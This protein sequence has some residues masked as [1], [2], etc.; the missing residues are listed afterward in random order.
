VSPEQLAPNKKE[1]HRRV[2]SLGLDVSP[3]QLT[4]LRQRLAAHAAGSVLLQPPIS[5]RDEM[6]LALLSRRSPYPLQARSPHIS[7][8]L[9]L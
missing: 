5:L 9:S 6:T 7:P 3:E 1:I 4:F 2:P 8:H